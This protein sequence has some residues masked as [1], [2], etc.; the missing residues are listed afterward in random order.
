MHVHPCCIYMYNLWKDKG[1]IPWRT[2][3]G[4]NLERL[5]LS[6]PSG[7]KKLS[8]INGLPGSWCM[9][10]VFFFYL[11]LVWCFVKFA[12]W[13]SL[14]QSTSSVWI[15]PLLKMLSLILHVE[16]LK[17][18]YKSVANNSKCNECPANSKSNT[19]RTGCL[20]YDGFYKKSGLHVAPCKG[21]YMYYTQDILW[22][23]FIFGSI[24][25]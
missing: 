15:D 9:H 20:C 25:Y 19:G 12:V 13:P 2:S 21:K 24:I 14:L 3:H 8:I 11:N 17:G 22:V 10:H 16:C 18:F 6:S 4:L 5:N 23:Q 7:Q 1:Q